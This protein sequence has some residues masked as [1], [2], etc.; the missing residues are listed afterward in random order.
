MKLCVTGGA[1]Y[2]GSVVAQALVGGGHEVTIVD[3][4]STGHMSALPDGCRF[5]RGDIRDA[6][7]L[8]EALGSGLDAVLHFA[9]LSVV[10][11]SVKKPLDYFDN[12]VGGTIRLLK[13][14]KEAGVKR[15]VFSSS[16]AVYGEPE[17]LPIVETD[18]C[19]P[20]NPYGF[21][22]F[23]VEQMLEA[24]RI[25]WGLQYV[26]LRYFNA[27]GSTDIHGEDHD[28]ETHLI[29]VVLDVASGRRGKFTIFGDDY[30]T[31]DGTC[32]RD[33]IH[34]HDLADAH[35]RAL[36]A[37][38]HAYFGILNLG[39]DSA[40]TVAQVVRTVE[41][42]TGRS[43]NHEIGGRRPGDPPALLASSKEAARILGWTKSRSSL[44]EIIRSAHEWRLQHPD[45]YQS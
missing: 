29:P 33:Y 4:L 42:I 7:V 16:A 41:R 43:V 26:S 36:S 35:I 18:A 45:G 11:D 3:N 44:E 24:S 1:G 17:R 9:A 30:D 19:K 10:G 28:P 37:M 32:L 6:G 5:V 21:S 23:A 13:S 27:G 31:P 40:F 2:I 25:A 22:K 20:S 38:D 8:G 34:V 12:N 39:S 15:I 14:M